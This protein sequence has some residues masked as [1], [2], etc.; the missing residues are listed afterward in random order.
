L[1]KNIRQS[2]HAKLLEALRRF[3]IPFNLYNLIANIYSAPQFIV[4]VGE[5]ES[6]DHIQHTGIRQGCRL[7]PYLRILVMTVLMS[8]VKSRLNTF[9]QND[10]IDGIKF[11]E[12]LY[13]DGTLLFGMYTR[14]IKKHLEEIQV[15]SAYYGMKLNLDKCINIIANRVQSNIFL[16]R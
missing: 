3:N 8:D 10:P 1:G 5:N 4:V 11:G 12:V 13:A 2:E 7:S 14:N 6:T 15:D 16:S 9:R